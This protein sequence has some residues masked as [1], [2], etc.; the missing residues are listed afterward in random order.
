MAGLKTRP[1]ARSVQAFLAGIPDERRAE[2]RRVAALM[3]RATR[4]KPEMW[5][6]KIVGFGRYRYGYDSGQ[7][8]EWFLTGFS[9]RKQ[10]LTLYIMS[11]CERHAALLRKLGRVKTGV[12]C[13]YVRRLSDVRLDVLERLI[14]ESVRHLRKRWPA[15]TPPARSAGSVRR[16]RR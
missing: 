11:G 15:L 10:A 2:C 16:S 3:R 12:G 1:T 9:P 7:R 8:G 4:T 5:G 14:R 13:L 6:A